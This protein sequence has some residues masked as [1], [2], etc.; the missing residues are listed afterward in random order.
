M[1]GINSKAKALLLCA[2]VPKVE[3][4]N[5]EP[6]RLFYT[7]GI[8]FLTGQGVSS[9]CVL[10]PTIG[11]QSIKLLITW[12][13]PLILE[14]DSDSL[15]LILRYI[16]TDIDILGPIMTQPDIVLVHLS[17]RLIW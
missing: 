5:T 6:G 12:V 15:S 13:H 16:K 14:I 1:P 10:D 9:L 7:L 11:Q 4:Y 17:R 2:T 8:T 3:R